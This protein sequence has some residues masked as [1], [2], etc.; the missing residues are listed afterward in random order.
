MSQTAAAATP[1]VG[2]IGDS[3]G[4]ASWLAVIAVLLAWWLVKSELPV[5]P[6]DALGTTRVLSTP[7]VQITTDGMSS[8]QRGDAA[9]AAGD[10]VSP[11]ED[12]ALFYYREALA[13]DA[14]D[15]AAQQGLSQVLAY[16]LNEAETA[17]FHG[18]YDQARSNAAMVLDID[19]NHAHARDV[20]TRATRL[21]RVEALLNQAV[22]LY[23][24]GRLTEPA[25]E[26]A[27][28]TYR[29]VL[30]IDPGNDAARQGLDSVVQRAVANAESAL[31]AGNVDQAKAHL[32]RVKA[33]DPNAPGLSSLEQ[34]ERNLQ[35]SE[36]TEQVRAWLTEAAEALEADRLMPPASPNAFT[37]YQRVLQIDAESA[38][39]RRGLELVR[40]GLVDRARTLLSSN[41][42]AATLAHL[43][44]AQQA[45]A[46]AAI[47]AELREEAAY[48]Q[49]LL[50]A[51]A[52][53]FDSL[54]PISQ[55]TPVRQ[56]PPAYPRTAPTGVS[57]SVDLQ[58]TV[59]ETGDVRDI[60][61]VG[62]PRDYFQRAA[63]AAV[64]GWRFEPVIERGRPIPVRVAVRVTFEG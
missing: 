15:E 38:A 57:G 54:Y 36:E 43:D 1:G 4:I 33:I 27:A 46:N 5:D 41:D 6:A 61:V 37:L 60:E 34:A 39:A 19:P 14:A 2:R 62:T 28:E 55:L 51:Q 64:R 63:V 49:R 24:A 47:V 17:I 10:I 52:G 58:L 21:Q 45:G 20:S 31:F 18:D 40:G 56:T 44:A 25:G 26:N 7:M 22:A 50:D 32:Q 3:F 42:M 16:L 9:F 29:Q 13:A 8:S 48:R 11:P 30:A 53:R 12:N 59:T 35:A 23:A